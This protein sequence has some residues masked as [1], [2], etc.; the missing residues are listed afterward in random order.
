M[1]REGQITDR[2]NAAVT[3]LTATSATNRAA[4]IYSLERIAKDSPSDRLAVTDTLTVFIRENCHKSTVSTNSGIAPDV[5]AALLVLGRRPDVSREQMRLDLSHCVL[6]GHNLDY[7]CW[8][9]AS[10]VYS[11]LLECWFTDSD[12]K[13]AC[14]AFATIRETGFV[15]AKMAGATFGH[16]RVGGF[17]HQADL[18]NV[19]F[20][21]ADLTGS[22]FGYVKRPDGSVYTSPA[23]LNGARFTGSKL[24]DVDFRGADLSRTIGLTLAQVLSTVFDEVTKWPPGI[25]PKT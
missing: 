3:Q 10:F 2:F 23:M 21:N 4:A 5:Q 8:R 19:D 13:Q 22:R 14:F 18:Q 17:F 11:E 24:N 7:G 9:D 12:C 1:N 15:G 20:S 6:C 16:A 25:V